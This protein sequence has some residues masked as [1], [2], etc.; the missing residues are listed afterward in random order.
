MKHTITWCDNVTG[1]V[2]IKFRDV[3]KTT[4]DENEFKPIPP[5]KRVYWKYISSIHREYLFIP[6]KYRPNSYLF[7]FIFYWQILIH[8]RLY[9]IYF[10][11][12]NFINT[13]G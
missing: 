6:N 12:D 1:E 7:N 9:Q 8:F 5:F 11:K 3:V 10:N 13:Y 4:L 2:E